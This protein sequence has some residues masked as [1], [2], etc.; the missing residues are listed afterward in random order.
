MRKRRTPSKFYKEANRTLYYTNGN[1]NKLITGPL[2]KD[3]DPLSVNDPLTP[4]NVAKMENNIFVNLRTQFS[5][6][7]RRELR[8]ETRRRLNEEIKRRKEQEKIIN[9]TVIK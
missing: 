4:D 5:Q 9:A 7:T 1:K 6:L 3:I 2:K 8:A